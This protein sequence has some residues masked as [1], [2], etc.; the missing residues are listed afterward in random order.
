[1]DRNDFEG[2]QIR[3]TV[4]LMKLRALSSVA[5]AGSVDDLF[6]LA[7]ARQRGRGRNSIETQEAF[8]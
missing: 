5:R 4:A 6:A 3:D 8:P 1:M 7:Y 2:Q